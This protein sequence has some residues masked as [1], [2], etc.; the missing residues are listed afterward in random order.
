MAPNQHHW[1]RPCHY[2]KI[3]FPLRQQLLLTNNH[4]LGTSVNWPITI[5]PIIS[6]VITNSEAEALLALSKGSSFLPSGR[7]EKKKNK[8]RSKYRSND[9]V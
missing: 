2:Y 7:L 5:I 4:I 6:P 3:K 9:Q 1:L 8:Q